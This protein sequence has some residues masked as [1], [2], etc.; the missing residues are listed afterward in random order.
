MSQCFDFGLLE[1]EVRRNFDYKDEWLEEGS[2]ALAGMAGYR[3]QKGCPVDVDVGSVLD[4][5]TRNG[6]VCSAEDQGPDGD[7]VHDYLGI[8]GPE[9]DGQTRPCRWPHGGYL[10][11]RWDQHQ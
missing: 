8:Y 2:H 5:D 9:P 1:G 4:G 7:E 6:S 3:I 10:T 11:K